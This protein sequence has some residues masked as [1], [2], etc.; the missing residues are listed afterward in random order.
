V[1]DGRRDIA[2]TDSAFARVVELLATH[3]HFHHLS[4]LRP[5]PLLAL[6]RHPEHGSLIVAPAEVWGHQREV[7][8]PYATR[9]AEGE[10]AVILLGRPRE[11]DP[12]AAGQSLVAILPEEPSPDELVVAL[13]TGFHLLEARARAESR[14]KH[15]KRYRYELSELIE[16]S[17]ALTTEREIDKLL[18]LILEKARFIT[19]ADAGSIYVVEGDDADLQRRTLR[20]KLSQN[21]SVKFDSREFTIPIS[22]RS[23]AGSAVLHRSAINLVDVYDIPPDQGFSFDPSF[24]RRIGY[25]TRSMLT[26]PL[27]NHRG[28][29]TGVLQLINKKRDPRALLKDPADIEAQVVPFDERSQELLA[30]LA[31]HAAIVLENALLYAEITALFEGFVKASVSAIEQ[32]DPTTSGHSRR[33]AD[34]TIAL[35]RAVELEGSGPYRDVAW[36]SQDIREIEYASLLHDFGKIGVR[37]QVLVKAKKLY[38]GQLEAI[39]MR[40]DFALRSLE[41]E[42]LHRRMRAAERSAPREEIEAIEAAF[43]DRRAD[44]E[45]SW[46][47]IVAANEPTVL[48]GGDFARV[49]AISRETYADLQGNLKPL[50]NQE[51]LCCLSVPRGSLTGVE[52]DEIRSHVTHT[53]NFLRTIPWGS[54]LRRVPLI[55]GAHHERLDG[56]GYPDRLRAE[57]IPLQSK[58]MSISDIFDALTAADR[59]YKRAVPLDRALDILAME[60]KEQHVDSDLFRIFCEARIWDCLHR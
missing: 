16:I 31:S 22:P 17:K 32:R 42:M 5:H 44:L 46:Q 18:N 14:G 11:A 6:L 15:L 29:V 7:L 3:P 20:F 24:D 25:L 36:T 13:Q 8:R 45:A 35:A 1:T 39:R 50:L 34:L 51:E 30:T 52:I 10:V 59:P 37:E 53:R 60:V 2:G 40:I 19:G 49:E 58:M 47:A 56:T 43:E 48:K 55:A 33:V 28:D 54:S 12:Q 27:I 41:V 57:Q 26:A 21:E 9:L 38:P 4:L 23:I